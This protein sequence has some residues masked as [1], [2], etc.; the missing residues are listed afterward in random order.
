M[1]KLLWRPARKFPEVHYFL[2]EKGAA[3]RSLGRKA[4]DCPGETFWIAGERGAAVLVHRYKPGASLLAALRG[5]TRH[6]ARSMQKRG[7]R[8]ALFVYPRDASPLAAALLP[9]VALSDY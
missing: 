7:S 4:P 2:P 6:A 3:P 8:E 1:A 5:A 9:H